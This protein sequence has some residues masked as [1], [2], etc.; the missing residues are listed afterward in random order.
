MK[1]IQLAIVISDLHCG[2]SAA[3]LPPEFEDHKGNTIGQNPVQKFLWDCWRRAEDFAKG[4]VDGD[5]YA[6]V[7]N[8]DLI[9]GIHHGAGELISNKTEDHVTCA[10]DVLVPYSKEASRI[11][12]VRGT[13]CHTGNHE[14]SLGKILK[15]HKN[16]DTHKRKATHAF[17]RLQLNLHG[18]EC[19]FSH[20]IGTSVRDYTEATQLGIVLNQELVHAVRNGEIPPRVVARAHRHKYGMFENGHE[21]AIVTPPWQAQTRHVHKVVTAVRCHPGVVILDWRGREVG[22]TPRV[23]RQIYEAPAQT[24]I[25]L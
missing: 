24:T 6:I 8:G 18:C 23:H 14:S 22:D 13:E 20:H 25:R 21:L 7:L 10:E 17:D 3:L 1:P 2:S 19:A 4:V 9:E 16:P 5:S 15:A 11:F 12:V